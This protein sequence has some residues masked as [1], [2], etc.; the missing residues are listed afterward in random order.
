MPSQHSPSPTTAPCGSRPMVVP[1]R[2]SRVVERRAARGHLL[3]R[4]PSTFGTRHCRWLS[5]LST[6]PVS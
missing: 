2:A 6:K 4:T 1:S 3:R 5:S